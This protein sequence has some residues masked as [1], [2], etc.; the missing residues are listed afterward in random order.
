[1]N[2]KYITPKLDIYSAKDLLSSAQNQYTLTFE[3]YRMAM[4][5]ERFENT[6]QIKELICLSSLKNEEEGQ[7][8]YAV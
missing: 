3:V 8:K 5:E 1:M 7:S 6:K 2:G 4:H